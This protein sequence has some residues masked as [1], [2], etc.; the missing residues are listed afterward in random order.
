[1]STVFSILNN[2]FLPGHCQVEKVD[3][4]AGVLNISITTECDTLLRA[5]PTGAA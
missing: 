2:V 1:M 4:Q 3:P 5:S